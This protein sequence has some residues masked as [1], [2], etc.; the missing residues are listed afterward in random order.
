MWFNNGRWY[1]K[2][3]LAGAGPTSGPHPLIG[4]TFILDDEDPFKEVYCEI[5][6]IRKNSKGIEYVSYYFLDKLDGRRLLGATSQKLDVFN[7]IWKEVK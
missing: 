5:V 1:G 2:K 3:Q 4:K 6:D 7:A